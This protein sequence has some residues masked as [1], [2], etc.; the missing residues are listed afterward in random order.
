[1][2]FAGVEMRVKG[3]LQRA[4]KDAHGRHQEVV[5]VEALHS[6]QGILRQQINSRNAQRAERRTSCKVS[7]WLRLLQV[8]SQS[9]CQWRQMKRQSH[10]LNFC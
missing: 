2:K 6:Q 5:K 7:P 9:T 8:L 1:M 3:I 4:Q 10:G